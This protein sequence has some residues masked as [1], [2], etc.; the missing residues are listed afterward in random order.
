[1]DYEHPDVP[2]Y[3]YNPFPKIVYLHPKGNDPYKSHL[4]K[5]VADD[6][7]LAAALKE[8]WSTKPHVGRDFS[9]CVCTYQRPQK[10]VPPKPKYAP[11]FPKLLSWFGHLVSVECKDAENKLRSVGFSDPRKG[12]KD[13]VAE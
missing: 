1:M 11:G 10:D 8:G 5:E 7:E 12:E 3:Q 13:F 6:A 9:V 4:T 2:P